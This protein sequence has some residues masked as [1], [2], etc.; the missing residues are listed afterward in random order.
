MTVRRL[1]AKRPNSDDAAPLE[2]WLD[3]LMVKRRALLME[4]EAIEVYLIKRGLL[5]GHSMRKKDRMK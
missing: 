3:L 2:D 1:S 5:K 4:L